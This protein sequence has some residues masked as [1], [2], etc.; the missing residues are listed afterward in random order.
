MIVK[1]S[2][3]QLQLHSFS[4]KED[5][6]GLVIDAY[7]RLDFRSFRVV[8]SLTLL[9]IAIIGYCLVIIIFMKS[10]GKSCYRNV[11]YG[12]LRGIHDYSKRNNSLITIANYFVQHAD[13]RYP[14]PLAH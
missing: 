14:C 4:I 8:G 7:K 3:P 1:L 2:I 9:L 5:S 13:K 10:Q 11:K 6:C 12:E